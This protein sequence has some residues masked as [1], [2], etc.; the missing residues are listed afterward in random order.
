MPII[1]PAIVLSTELSRSK[2]A[3]SKEGDSVPRLTSD[4]SP[5]PTPLTLHRFTSRFAEGEDSQSKF[6]SSS[7]VVD[8]RELHEKFRLRREVPI[9]RM[10]RRS[11]SAES[12]ARHRVS[13][14]IDEIRI[15]LGVP[16]IPSF[17]PVL[18][19]VHRTH[20]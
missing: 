17:H 14:R 18:L 3:I 8:G 19:E 2:R 7:S 9:E 5:E 12:S 15:A 1:P 13:L 4:L 10:F 16:S 6:L 20:R 11:D